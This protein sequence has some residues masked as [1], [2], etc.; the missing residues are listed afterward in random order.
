MAGLTLGIRRRFLNEKKVRFNFAET[1]LKNKDLSQYN[2]QGYEPLGFLFVLEDGP[3]AVLPL[4]SDILRL[5]PPASFLANFFTLCFPE[6]RASNSA[7]SS[8]TRLFDY[9]YI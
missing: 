6:I 5:R 8:A 1:E 4:S 9:I 7:S 2:K 3:L